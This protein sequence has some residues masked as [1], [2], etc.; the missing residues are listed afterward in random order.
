[1]MKFKSV[2]V[3]EANKVHL[4][5]KEKLVNYENILTKISAQE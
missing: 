1:M 5:L 3:L 2:I 4:A